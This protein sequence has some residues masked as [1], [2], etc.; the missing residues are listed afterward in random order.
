MALRING[1]A[2]LILTRRSPAAKPRA[3]FA[4]SKAATPT[5]QTICGSH[6]LSAWDRSVAVAWRE[7]LERMPANA[8]RIQE[9]QR[10]W[11]HERDACGTDADC[12][13]T[14]MIQR[15]SDLVHE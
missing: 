5:E 7:A 14:Q 4:C 9:Q 15:V 2:L 8:D 3:S 12:L 6:A 10:K 13:E 1:S 11:L